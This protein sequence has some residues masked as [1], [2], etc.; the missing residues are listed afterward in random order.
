MGLFVRLNDL[1]AAA[2]ELAGA[3]AR[4]RWKADVSALGSKCRNHRVLATI[5]SGARNKNFVKNHQ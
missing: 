2:I 3:N 5:E 1:L 4:M